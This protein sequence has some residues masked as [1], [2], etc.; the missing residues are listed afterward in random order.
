MALHIQ[1]SSEVKTATNARGLTDV[2]EVEQDLVLGEKHSKDMLEFFAR[3]PHTC[4][5]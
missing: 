4:T 2:G 1:L 5:P 3:K